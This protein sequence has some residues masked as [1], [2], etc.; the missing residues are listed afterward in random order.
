[1]T[2]GTALPAHQLSSVSKDAV[3]L[4]TAIVATP[5][6]FSGHFIS[7]AAGIKGRS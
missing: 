7:A 2:L 5:T 3:K 6:E 1:M 4:A